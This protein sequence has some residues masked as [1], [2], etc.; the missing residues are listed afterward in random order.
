MANLVRSHLT[1]KYDQRNDVAALRKTR[2]ERR[3]ALIATAKAAGASDIG[4]ARLLAGLRSSARRVATGS[5]TPRAG[6]VAAEQ[7][8]RAAVAS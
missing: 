1:S 2:D 6:L 3:A 4:V 7:L 8:A 5:I